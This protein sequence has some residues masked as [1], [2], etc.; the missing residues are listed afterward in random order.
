MNTFRLRGNRLEMLRIRNEPLR[1][2]TSA[3][4]IYYVDDFDL[5]GLLDVGSTTE[6]DAVDRPRRIPIANVIR[7]FHRG[8]K[9]GEQF[10]PEYQKM[11]DD[12]IQIALKYFGE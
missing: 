2:C 6:I 5:D 11:Y 1:A 12:G 10:Q 9:R 3:P 8:T 7:F 4:C